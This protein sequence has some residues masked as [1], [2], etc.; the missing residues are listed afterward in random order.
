MAESCLHGCN[1]SEL[2]HVGD[3]LCAGQCLTFNM[4]LQHVSATIL[5]TCSRLVKILPFVKVS[6]LCEYAMQQ[7]KMQLLV[8]KQKLSTNDVLS[9]VLWHVACDIRSRPR[10]CQPTNRGHGC[11][12]YPSNLRSMHVPQHYCGNALLVNLLGGML[13]RWLAC[14]IFALSALQMHPLAEQA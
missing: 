5:M 7:V 12:A 8:P 6:T 2:H 14:T 10:P 9:A 4:C 1:V 3:I 13:V 11:L